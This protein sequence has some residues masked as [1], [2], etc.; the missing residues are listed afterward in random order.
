MLI[1][2]SKSYGNTLWEDLS[3]GRFI[4]FFLITTQNFPT[5]FLNSLKS[6]KDTTD[7][8][9]PVPSGSS[10]DGN[11]KKK[12]PEHKKRS[13]FEELDS[14]TKQI[15]VANAIIDNKFSIYFQAIFSWGRDILKPPN[16]V[17][18]SRHSGNKEPNASSSQ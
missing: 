1:K 2:A 11:I 13:L 9:L 6:E 5:S 17:N 4:I 18:P 10:D 14:L 3:L 8:V 7:N 16:D 15:L 12:Q